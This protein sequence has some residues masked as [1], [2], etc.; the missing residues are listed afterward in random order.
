MRILITGGTGLI[1]SAL[2]PRLLAENHQITALVRNPQRAKQIL[3]PEV[4]FISG[5]NSLPNLDQFDGVI[6]L[7]GEPIFAKR[8]SAERKRALYNSRISLTNQISQLINQG[9]NPPQ[10]LISGSACG[11]YGDQGEKELDENAPLGRNFAAQLAQQ[12]EMAALNAKTR[13]CL[14]R[15]G[16]VLSKQGGALAKMLPI[17]KAGLAGKIG[18]GQQFW[19]WIALQ[20]MLNGILFL[21]NKP[22]CQGVFNFA[23]PNPERNQKFNDLL[24]TFLKRPALFAVPACALRLLLGERACLLL[25]SQNVR[26]AHLLQQ[27]F[28]FEFSN[29]ADFLAQELEG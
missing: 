20:D 14:I 24:K 2:I 17:Y 27:G 8:W 1:G 12:W 10:F 25:D 16:L 11:Y 29:L 21:I 13:V 7:A 4:Q 18:N 22:N 15:T 23:A 6:N 5:L 19:P 26:P 28:Q 3:P 9:Q